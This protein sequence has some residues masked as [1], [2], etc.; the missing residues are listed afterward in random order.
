MI[1]DLMIL[2]I[3]MKLFLAPKK[4]KGKE[5]NTQQ[6]NPQFKSRNRGYPISY[7]LKFSRKLPYTERPYK[8]YPI[9]PT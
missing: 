5:K 6:R 9:L 4:I 7:F 8:Q 3:E 2:I 1:S